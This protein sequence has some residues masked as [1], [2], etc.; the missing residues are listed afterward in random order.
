MGMTEQEKQEIKGYL[1][2]FVKVVTDNLETGNRYPEEVKVLP[3][4][5]DILLSRF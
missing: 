5:V 4:I 2:Q 3:D 1:M